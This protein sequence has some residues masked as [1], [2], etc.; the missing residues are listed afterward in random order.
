[1]ARVI[2]DWR[3]AMCSILAPLLAGLAATGVASMARGVDVSHELGKIKVDQLNE[4]SGLASSRRNADVLWLNNDG[5]LGHLFAV[6]TSGKLV[7]LVRLRVAISD[8][9][10]ITLGP[11][12]ERGVDYLYLGDIGDNSEKRREIRVVRFA[13]PNL[14]GPRGQQL[15]VDE[16]EEFRL[17][18]PDG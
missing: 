11:G 14:S 7:A 3:S 9:E 8:L 15:D 18:Y 6:S 2:F 16:A 12:P 5:D 13:E 10:E 17:I 1:M 4:I